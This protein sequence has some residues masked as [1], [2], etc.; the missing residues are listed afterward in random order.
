MGAVFV[1]LP[2]EIILKNSIT[3]YDVA[4]SVPSNTETN[5]ILYTV[6][7]NQTFIINK[8]K[9]GGLID[10]IYKLYIN[11]VLKEELSSNFYIRDPV[12]ITQESVTQNIQIK[13]TAKHGAI[14]PVDFN[15]T[16]TGVLL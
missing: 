6:P 4:L 7:I 2:T 16:I 14:T 12:F 11:N 8:S 1:P 3:V 5:I 13:I 10:A 15:A 9:A